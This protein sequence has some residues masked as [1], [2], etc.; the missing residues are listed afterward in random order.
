MYKTPKEPFFFCFKLEYMLW[1]YYIAIKNFYM[2]K[3]ILPIDVEIWYTNE[4]EKNEKIEI[5]KDLLTTI[6]KSNNKLSTW[7][8]LKRYLSIVRWEKQSRQFYVIQAVLTFIIISLLSI[9]ILWL[10]IRDGTVVSNTYVWG[11]EAFGF[12]LVE[13]KENNKTKLDYG[14]FEINGCNDIA[15]NT[16]KWV[17]IKRFIDYYTLF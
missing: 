10:S 6:T 1:Y 11:S 15:C 3:V 2:K 7:R 12:Y 9:I 13:D 8:R 4:N 5:I 14:R 16:S 17:V